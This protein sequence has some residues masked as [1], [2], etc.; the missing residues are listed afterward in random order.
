M[1]TGTRLLVGP[2]RLTGAESLTGQVR[3]LKGSGTLVVALTADDQARLHHHLVFQ[4][5]LGLPLQ[6]A[7]LQMGAS[8]PCPSRRCPWRK[9]AEYSL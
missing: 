2:A 4:Q 7:L 9:A 8:R 5:K 1:R 3:T 6:S